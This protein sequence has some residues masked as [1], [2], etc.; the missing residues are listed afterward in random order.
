MNIRLSFFA[1]I[2]LCLVGYLNG[3]AVCLLGSVAAPV[4]L[5]KKALGS[6][7]PTML[8]VINGNEIELRVSTYSSNI[9][10]IKNMVDVGAAML[11][12]RMGCNFIECTYAKWPNSMLKAAVKIN[13]VVT[14]QCTSRTTS[15]TPGVAGAVGAIIDVKKK[16]KY[17]SDLVSTINNKNLLVKNDG[18]AA[19]TSSPSQN[20]SNNDPDNIRFVQKQLL[21]L[22]YNPGPVD[23]VMGTQT[24]EALMEYQKDHGLTPTGEIDSATL[25]NLKKK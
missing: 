22:G 2:L 19:N 25:K 1:A 24:R 17:E 5:S 15:N 7:A 23:G 12:D 18:T 6:A 16:L 3:C 14:Y 21:D 8:Y 4:G 20:D 11:A 10:S 9:M 13:T